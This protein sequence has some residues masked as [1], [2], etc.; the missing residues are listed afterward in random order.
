MHVFYFIATD[1][2][3][4]DGGVKGSHLYSDTLFLLCTVESNTWD[5][6]SVGLIG[7]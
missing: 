4:G 3:Y 5:V 1:A 7:I 2:D 6:I